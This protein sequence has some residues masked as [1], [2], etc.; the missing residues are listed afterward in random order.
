M[1]GDRSS[2]LAY[3]DCFSG[4]SGDM[5]LGALLDLGVPVEWLRGELARMPMGDFELEAVRVERA[6][7]TALH[8]RVTA[9][10]AGGARHLADIRRIVEGASYPERVRKRSIDIFTRLAEA[11]AA[12]HGTTVEEVHFHEVGAV[13]AIVDVV[14]TA[15]GLERLGIDRVTCSPIPITSGSVACAHGVLPLPAP[16]VAHLLRGVPVYGLESRVETV[17]PTGAAIVTTL[18]SGF[19]APPEMVLG[20][21]GCGAGSRDTPGRPNILRILT[22]E[23]TGPGGGA[24]ETVTI[25]ECAIDDMSPELFGYL[26]ERLLEDGA[27]DVLWLPAHMKK[28]RPGTLVQVLCEPGGASV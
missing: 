2:K 4:V 8:V 17:T 10:E 5:T 28:N 22:G 12:V 6:G 14:G 25:V 26:M 21:A 27:L 1:I 16:A 9:P 7:M 15:L 11:E 23:E 20:P 19:G 3:F 18:A 24:V 13:D